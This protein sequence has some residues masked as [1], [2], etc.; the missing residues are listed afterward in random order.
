MRVGEDHVEFDSLNWLQIVTTASE[1]VRM[2]GELSPLK[3][4]LRREAKA[5]RVLCDTTRRP[6]WMRA[7]LDFGNAIEGERSA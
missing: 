5:G 6:E 2:K 7:P 1:I 4:A 3:E